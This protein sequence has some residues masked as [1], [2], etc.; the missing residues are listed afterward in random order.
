MFWETKSSRLPTALGGVRNRPPL[1]RTELATGGG[2]DRTRSEPSSFFIEDFAREVAWRNSTMTFPL[3]FLTISS[4]FFSLSFFDNLLSRDCSNPS[5]LCNS[6]RVTPAFRLA[7]RRYLE[8][9]R[10]SLSSKFLGY[11]LS[12][13]GPHLAVPIC[14]G[15]C[16]LFRCRYPGWNIA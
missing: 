1:D 9:T 16:L 13:C 8:R 3:R 4:H 14:C 7:R 12:P 5:S 6:D 10:G 11:S 15:H 2:G